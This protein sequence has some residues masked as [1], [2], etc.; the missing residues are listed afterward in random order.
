MQWDIDRVA[1]VLDAA[2]IRRASGPSGDDV[3]LVVCFWRG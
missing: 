1:V 2:T 3:F